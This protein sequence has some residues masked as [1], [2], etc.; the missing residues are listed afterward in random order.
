[1]KTLLLLLLLA[2]PAQA[3]EQPYLLRVSDVGEGMRR[4]SVYLAPTTESINTVEGTLAFPK[5]VQEGTISTGGSVVLYYIEQPKL[6]D[7]RVRFAGIIPNGFTNTLYSA[8]GAGFL[9]S[10]DVPLTEGTV[11]LRDAMVLRNDGEGTE[12]KAPILSR[13]LGDATLSDTV[14]EDAAPPEWVRAERTRAGSVSQESVLIL[15]AIDKG[16]GVSHFEVKEGGGTWERT[17]T[18]YLIKNSSPFLHI[19]VR[20]VDYAGNVKQTFVMSEVEQYALR[21]LPYILGVIL[22]GFG[23]VYLA[24]RFKKR[25]TS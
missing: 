16:S 21:V 6:Q 5:E 24:R 8:D 12:V 3:Q 11:S 10:V 22:L 14:S 25:R 23:G 2:L 9:F 7:E 4:V 19:Y 15:S 1:M 13:S 18:P 17:Q 20:A